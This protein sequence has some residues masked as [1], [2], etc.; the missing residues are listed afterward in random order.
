[1]PIRQTYINGMIPS[2]QRA[3]ILSFDS[4]MSSTGGVWAQPVLG[5]AADAWGYATSYVISAG[6]SALAVPCLL[7]SRRQNAPA[8]TVEI[9]EAEPAPQPA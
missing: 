2:R 1:M 4:M 7:L 8:D 6:I 9:T 5:R 3:S